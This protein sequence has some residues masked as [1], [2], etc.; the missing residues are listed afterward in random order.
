[1]TSGTHPGWTVD[2]GAQVG[3]VDLAHSASF[4]LG[5]VLVEPSLRRLSRAGGEAVTVEPRVMQVLVT[6][7]DAAGGVVSR[8]DLI[9]R[10]WGGRIVSE[11]AINRVVSLLRKVAE[12][13]GKGD[14]T[15]ETIPRVGFRLA[16]AGSP[17]TIEPVEANDEPARR[18]VSAEPFD[19]WNR[20][21]VLYGLTAA[22]ATLALPFGIA[23]V[24]ER[25]ADLWP[26]HR[27]NAEASKLY[28]AG[29][30][31]Q[32]YSFDIAEQAETFFLRAAQ[33]DPQWAD[34]WGSLAMSY[35]HALDGNTNT[36]Q[37]RLVEQT[38][39]AANRALE[40]D[41][42][43]AEALVA[44]ALIASPLGRWHESEAEYVRMVERF[45][46]AFVMRGHY[47]RL[48]RDLGRF[49]DAV[50]QTA[51]IAADHP[52]IPYVAAGHLM[53][54]WGAGRTQEA[55][56]ESSRS[57]NLFPKNPLI[58]FMRATYLTFTGRPV[59]AVGFAMNSEGW[60]TQMPPF[61]FERRRI[62]AQAILTREQ[63]DIDKV[64]AELNT[65]IGNSIRQEP[66]IIDPT[67]PL[68]FLVAVGDLDTAFDLL[69]S[70]YFGRGRFQPRVAPEVGPLTRRDTWLL[71]L[72]MMAP[73]RADR[74]FM[75]ILEEIRMVDSYRASRK[76]PDW[77][78]SR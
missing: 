77:W 50:V 30:R 24:R 53:A 41:P 56:A 67:W 70:Y 72:P 2:E 60:P 78:K 28:E 45:P 44:L 33:A 69:D 36:A 32:Y 20:R 43:N 11:N 22:G 54:L 18:V 74:R 58:W 68:P 64:M 16:G 55:D 7:R 47:S 3:A 40:L 34:A 12:T 4:R 38:R 51:R 31:A 9:E 14:F 17:E 25:V 66:Y 42:R 48:L 8:D 76:W 1:M 71:H 46:A 52:L 15:V 26:G 39:A 62:T 29:M 73:L 5:Q 21:R 59:E 19:P 63:A 57:I 6:L 10:C 13:V 23:S 27:P 49:D 61:L 35:R 37:W 75:P 65:Y